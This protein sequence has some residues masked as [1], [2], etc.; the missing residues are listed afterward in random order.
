MISR[1]QRCNGIFDVSSTKGQR[2][3]TVTIPTEQN[4]YQTHKNDS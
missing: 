1:T 2:A 4:K 3:Q